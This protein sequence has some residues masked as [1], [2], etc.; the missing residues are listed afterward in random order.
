MDMEGSV[1]V[2]GGYRYRCD[3]VVGRRAWNE[4]W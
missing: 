1:D 4:D 3:D 2:N